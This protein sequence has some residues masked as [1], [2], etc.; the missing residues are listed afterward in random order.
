MFNSKVD[1]NF[2]QVKM[3]PLNNST[4]KQL[5]SFSK[6]PRFNYKVNVD[7]NSS[8]FYEIKGTIG[9][10]NKGVSFGL[11]TKVDFSKLSDKTPG[12]GSYKLEK[13]KTSTYLQKHTMGIGRTYFKQ[14][15]D[16]PSVGK[17]NIASSIIK[18]ERI[19]HFGQKIAMKD[20]TC[21]PGPGK[22]DI[23]YKEHSQS[24]IYHPVSGRTSRTPDYIPG[25]QQY[26]PK[27]ELSASY[28]N[29][30][31]S[32]CNVPKFS[33]EER[34][35][36]KQ[37]STPGPGKYQ[38][39]GEFVYLRVRPI[40]YD[41]SMLSI[42]QNVISIKD[43]TNKQA[44][45]NQYRYDKIFPSSSTQQ[46]LFE[47][48]FSFDYENKNGCI[49]SY[50]Q[51]GSGKSY[52]LFGN[53][54]NP[55]IV[56]LLIQQLLQKGQNVQVSFQEIYVD[57]IKD[58][59]TNLITEE[60]TKRQI[61]LIND[62]WEMIKILR[63]T[64][65]K[66]QMRTHIILTLEINQNTKLQFVDLAGSERVAKNI[67][68]GEK[69]Q[70]A[71]LITAS[72]QVLNRCL[73]SFNQNPNKILPKK[74]SKLTSA[75]LIDNN[76]Q[77][78]LIGAINPSQSNYEECLLTLQ[79]LDRTKN[80]QVTIKK[81]QSMLG[82]DNQ[83]NIQQ[84]KEIKKLKDEIEEYKIK[85]EQLNADRKKRFLELQ[86]LLGLDID[87]ERL[88]AKNAKD[89]TIFKN[90][91]EAL[92]KNVSLQQ[93]IDE[94]HYENAQLKKEIE[95]LKKD[96]HNK[97][98]RYQQQILE[99]KEINKKLKD[100]LQLSKMS[101]DDAIRLLSQDRDQF[102]KKLQDE[103]K[104]LLEDKVASILNL[105]Q[106]AQTKNVEN[107]KLQELKKLIKTEVEKEFNKS[108][109]IIKTEYN[110]SLDHYKFQ[111]EQKLNAKVE[112]IE[113]F[114]NQF[115]KYREKKKSQ[116]NEIV[117]E[118]LDLYDIITKQ[119]KVIDKIE[120]GG[121]SGGLKS[122]S[123]PKQDKPN[124]PNKVKHKNLFHFLE[125]KSVTA[126]L[127]KKASNV[128][129]TIKTATKQLRQSQ[130]QIILEID[131][132][133]LDSIN[134]MSMDFSTLR[135]YANKLREMIKE[136][137]DQITVNSDKFKQQI[138]QLQRERDDAQQKYNME[139]RKYNQTR[140]VIES[141]NRILSKVRPLSSVSRKQ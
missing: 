17:Y 88:S 78:V 86:R 61:L 72:H 2:K 4:S 9:S 30:N 15:N 22:Y 16:M 18:N 66:R 57:Q 55:G 101:G 25:P 46:E 90:Q 119:G 141:Q 52:S 74:E 60:F 64:D 80:I 121:Y 124:L 99:Q 111:Y 113:S 51:S 94:Y 58:L 117:E 137:Q 36:S 82:F 19:P 89:I 65:I 140:V 1:E 31:W 93:Q 34:F 103:S 59:N 102:I 112:E 56:P 126:T 108:L 68:E 83:V 24:V 129:K 12:P 20:E 98:E 130:S 106:T 110:K 63:T 123:I 53:I 40:D 105:P 67:T 134:F 13:E 3:N 71:I 114:L 120:T 73:N 33:K 70:E 139:S 23:Q 47:S 84:E 138:A 11:G 37:S 69:F 122:F 41:Q 44:E 92:L 35:N 5:Y 85:I 48:V 32:N 107:Q 39:P 8:S 29:S 81:Q 49:I 79:Y 136:L 91:Q 95:D 96:T 42:D 87:L 125:T 133:Q 76:T 26:R 127:T 50:G 75:L 131:Y 14:K 135:T 38:I 128:E 132:N 97:L 77:V 6:S 116:I 100:Q 43:P 118:L 21:T 7:Q 27:T 10:P 104:N 109:E 62:F 45:W 115:K 28:V 54:Q